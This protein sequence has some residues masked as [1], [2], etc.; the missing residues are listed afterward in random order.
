[1]ISV[2]RIVCRRDWPFV[3]QSVESIYEQGFEYAGRVTEIDQ[4]V[5]AGAP[6]GMWDTQMRPEHLTSTPFQSYLFCRIFQIYRRTKYQLSPG[7]EINLNL[8]SNRPR[9]VYMDK[10]RGRS[11]A[12]GLT[13]GYFIDFQGVPY[14]DNGTAKSH[15]TQLT[16]QKMVRYSLTMMPGKRPAT[17]YDTPDPDPGEL[18]A[19]KTQSEAR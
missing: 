11:M 10:V 17:S 1:M 13:H 19:T 12:R 7:E 14:N 5:E 15:V 2:Y 9:I 6:F 4:P 18:V 16:V 8:K 3:N